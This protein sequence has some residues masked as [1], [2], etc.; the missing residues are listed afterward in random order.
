MSANTSVEAL[1]ASASPLPQDQALSGLLSRL[2]S[3]LGHA[4]PA[5]RF[6]M[7][8]RSQDGIEMATL[9]PHRRARE[10]WKARFSGAQIRELTP[11]VVKRGDY[12]LLWIS[13]SGVDVRIV[14]GRLSHGAFS[15]EGMDGISQEIDEANVRDGHLLALRAD[16]STEGA[17]EDGPQTATDWFAFAIRKHRRVFL[18]GVFATFMISAIG[19][20]AS[21]YTM[22]VY[23]RVV[24]TKGFS[25]LWVLTIGVLLAVVLEFTMKQVRAHMVDRASKVIDQE[26]SS[27][28]FDKALAIRMDARPSTVGTFASQIRHFESVRNFMTSTT[29]FILADAPFAL[30]FI[31]VMAMIAGPVALVPLVMVPVAVIAGLFFRG[32]IERLSA[33]NMQE[34]NRKNGLLIEAVDGIESVKAAGGEWKMLDRYRDLT[35]TIAAS[36]LQLKALSTRSTNLAQTIQQLNYVGL[37]AA[38]AYAIS[39][40][41][42]SMGGLIACSIIS[43]RALSPL[44]QIPQLVVQWKHAKIALK[45]LDAIMAMP[46]DRSSHQRLVVPERCAGQLR[47]ESATFGYRED[48]PILE[49]ADLRIQP[50]ERIAVLG[51][52][53]SGKSTLVKMLSGLYKPKTGAAYL[54]GVDMD[55]LAPEF[56]REHIGYLPQDVRLFSGTLREN[57]TLGLPTPSD[58]VIFNAARL[59]GLDQAIQSHPKGLELEITEGGR[60]L[61]GGQRQL[62][63]LTRLLLARSSVMLL[64]EPT[65]SMD[66]QLESRVMKH[67]FQEAPPESVLV[68]VT[69]KVGMLPHVH[70]IIVVDKGRIVMDGPRDQVLARL[71]GQTPNA[72]TGRAAAAPHTHKEISS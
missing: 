70:R 11:A 30:M 36:E 10:M 64:D 68:V 48:K 66:V 56:V 35:A 60:G 2:A 13:S 18:D 4:V 22:Q 43:G 9:A 38:G 8:E 20:T 41:Q 26:L 62:V 7:L 14:R 40:G 24:P 44:A 42:L 57:L 34:S 39:S 61:S 31:G 32:S 25:T 67:L 63:G 5:F 46:S 1:D 17:R 52:V 51:A 58:S 50:G 15:T 54:D 3:L 16:E 29:L 21:L 6:S 55:Q 28:F 53:G 69:H 65:A 72:I 71:S 19:L 12:P 45:S 27:V 23:D 37:I 49:I 33:E 47:L 59:T